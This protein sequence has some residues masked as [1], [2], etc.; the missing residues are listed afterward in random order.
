MYRLI[1]NGTCITITYTYSCE[2]WPYNLTSDSVS[3]LYLSDHDAVFIEVS[4]RPHKTSQPQRKVFCYKKADHQCIK[5]GLR[6]PM[7]DMSA[8]MTY[9]IDA[10]FGVA[11]IMQ[12]THVRNI[13]SNIQGRSLK[14]LKVIFHSIR[15][16]S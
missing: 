10:L 2:Y 7:Q 1:T 13:N 9:S 5:Y 11:P 14:V 16:C 3:A 4:L 8:M 6:Q 15:N 12:V